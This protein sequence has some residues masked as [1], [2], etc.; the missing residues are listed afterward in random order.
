MTKDEQE[1]LTGFLMQSIT[2]AGYDYKSGDVQFKIDLLERALEVLRYEYK[3]LK[4]ELPFEE[5]I[6]GF[7]SLTHGRL[8]FAAPK[9]RTDIGT[10]TAAVRLQPKLLM[11]L[12]L[13]HRDYYK[14][15]DIIDKFIEKIWDE[16]QVVDFKKT[17]TGVT[18]CFTNTR[19]AA[20][21]LRDY[22]FLKYTNKEAFKTWTLSLPGF[23][24]ASK[25][26]ED[27]NWKIPE[28]QKQ[29]GFDLHPDIHLAWDSLQTF[30]D[31][32]GRL[33]TLCDP[34][35]QVFTTFEPVLKKAHKML[36]EYWKALRE[37]SWN[38]ADRKK[39]SLNRLRLLEKDPKME[40]FYDQ[41][42]KCLL[43]TFAGPW[44][45]STK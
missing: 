12:L 8:N 43:E 26:L 20:T 3:H 27:Q 35:T 24:V 5:F 29:T 31:F 34:K 7:V 37:D 38:Q 30:D 15:F 6:S 44:S 9:K 16:L 33:K 42:S 19:F 2:S 39:E 21:T 36:A 40:A 4:N 25:V 1:I 13:Y 10:G 22:G 18:R 17:Q 41:F 32:T 11:F 28:T 14:V 23:L 45:D